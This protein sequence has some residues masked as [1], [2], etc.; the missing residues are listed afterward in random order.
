MGFLYVKT[1]DG[2][3]KPSV[4]VWVIA[5][6]IILGVSI[7]FVTNKKESGLDTFTG[8]TK[9]QAQKKAPLPMQTEESSK[10]ATS[11]DL[12]ADSINKINNQIRKETEENNG[13][14]SQE[15]KD[16]IKEKYQKEYKEKQSANFRPTVG[17]R[18]E[19]LNNTGTTKPTIKPEQ[20]PLEETKSSHYKTLAERLGKK[21]GQG[22]N[23][24]VS[25]E[26]SRPKASSTST[27]LAETPIKKAEDKWNSVKNLL[28]LGTFIPCVLDG[29]VVTSD[30]SSYVWVNVVLDVTFR[31]QMQLPKG[32]VRLRGKTATEPVQNVVDIYF[33]TMVFSDGTELP[34]SGSAYAAFDPRYPTRYKTRGVPG[35]MIVPPYYVKLKSL[36]Y[37][38]AYGASQA[39]VQNFIAQNTTTP[40]TFTT[41]PT[42]NPTTGQAS[43]VIQQVQGQPYNSQIGATVGLSAA[44]SALQQLNQDTQKDLEKYKPYVIVEKGTPLFVQLDKTVNV[45]DRRINGTAIARAEEA[46]LNNG[47][48]STEVYAQGDARARYTGYGPSGYGVSGA[49][50]KPDPAQATQE[51]LKQLQGAGDQAVQNGST[52]GGVPPVNSVVAPNTGTT[53][54]GGAASANPQ[55]TQA[56]QQLLQNIG[57][58]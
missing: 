22:G 37:A 57:N 21:D 44:Q 51:F 27:N 20:P 30:L 49:T 25:T 26:F 8:K 56:L 45:G 38:A 47:K 12:D 36:L 18:L 7:F 14:L 50:A 23:H 13:Y 28:P 42:I 3:K 33:D 19:Q 46:Q 6:A 34:I 17:N 10:S 53:G 15:R 55:N 31:R 1:A 2:K 4:W 40:S 48:G 39:Y 29:D 11:D 58:Q 16:E 43:S 41:V 9:A 52:A 35:E 32:L 5:M 54:A 24:A